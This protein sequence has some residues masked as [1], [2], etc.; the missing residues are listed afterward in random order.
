[1]R[2]S[3]CGLFVFAGFLMVNLQ[4]AE[5][6]EI[7]PYPLH[8]EGEASAS[9][10]QPAQE[11]VEPA[12]GGDSFDL[13]SHGRWSVS[14]G[15]GLYQTVDRWSDL[16]NVN[17]IWNVKGAFPALVSSDV[18]GRYEDAVRALFD[19]YQGRSVRPV[20]T[21][22]VDPSTQKKTLVVRIAKAD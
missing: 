9:V 20:A 22:H 21:L 17:L 15:D 1:M 8:A 19:Q 3:V 11:L 2:R 14:K 12:S 4:F 10:D 16:E 7:N 18:R 5:A 6:L 13:L